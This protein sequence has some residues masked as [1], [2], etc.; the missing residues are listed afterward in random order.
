MTARVDATSLTGVSETT[1]LTLYCRAREA[2]RPD[3]VIDD[4]LA[5]RLLTQI[6][7]DFTKFEQTAI[8]KTIPQAFRPT[9]QYFAVRAVSIDRAIQDFLSTH[10]RGTVIALAEGLQTTFWRI[11][12]PTVRW[13]SLDLPA[14]ISLRERLLPASP[15]ITNIAGSALDPA[16][17]EHIDPHSPTLI[18][19]EG[20]LMY[21]RP[22]EALT[23]INDCARHNPS[24]AMIFDLAPPPAKSPAG[25][26]WTRRYR[27]PPMTFTLT[28]GQARQFAKAIP[29]VESATTLPYARGRGFRGKM[30]TV[31]PKYPVLCHVSSSITLL[32]FKP[33][34]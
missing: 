27:V 1:L 22:E 11:N 10:P 13:I 31:L 3:P 23:L 17:Y 2:A 25:W 5:V 30:Q 15:Q 7:Y 9:A 12:S 4:P 14:V 18:T 29:A 21:L 26:P 33:S 20:L 19:A 28:S 6:D 8:P 24:G 16:W 34:S 32:R